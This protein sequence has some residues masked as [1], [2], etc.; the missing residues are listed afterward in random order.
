MTTSPSVRVDFLYSFLLSSINIRCHIDLQR[1]A[2]NFFRSHPPPTPD[3]CHVADFF[4]D[5]EQERHPSRSLDLGTHQWLLK[6]LAGPAFLAPK[7]RESFD[8]HRRLVKSSGRLIHLSE[9]EV[10]LAA[11]LPLYHLFPHISVGYELC[12]PDAGWSIVGADPDRANRQELLSGLAIVVHAFVFESGAGMLGLSIRKHDGT[13]HPATIPVPNTAD[14]EHLLSLA[15]FIG[16]EQDALGRPGHAVLLRAPGHEDCSLHDLYMRE[17][18]WFQEMLR[19]L[20]DHAEQYSIASKRAATQCHNLESVLDECANSAAQ[21]SN[22]TSMDQ[23]MLAGLP[24][25]VPASSMYHQRPY[26][27][28]GAELTGTTKTLPTKLLDELPLWLSVPPGKRSVH[29]LAEIGLQ[30]E[31]GAVSFGRA[32]TWVSAGSVAELDVA[33][34]LVVRITGSVRLLWHALTLMSTHLGGELRRLS[35]MLAALEAHTDRTLR[36]RQSSETQREER[37]ERRLEQCRSGIRDIRSRLHAFQLAEDPLVNAVHFSS[38][39]S[40]FKQFAGQFDFASVKLSLQERVTALDNLEHRSRQ[41][42]YT[43]KTRSRAKSTFIVLVIFLLTI[44]LVL[45]TLIVW[46]ANRTHDDVAPEQ[47][48]GTRQQ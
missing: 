32:G 41:R 17:L 21:F 24:Q 4:N 12:V 47:T 36:R 22:I 39:G 42:L 14:R 44:T 46:N 40:A 25:S 8:D 45:G 26:V 11:R 2:R 35:D 43:M 9:E 19:R 27:I 10:P 16:D 5:L 37:W 38:Y 28:L 7:I 33:M 30:F 34:R 13:L 48:T 1:L 18:T 29:S 3:A 20:G 31:A 15:S 23:Q 6:L